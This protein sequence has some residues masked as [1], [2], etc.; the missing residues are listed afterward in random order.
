M[1]GLRSENAA[2]EGAGNV[3][4]IERVFTGEDGKERRVRMLVRSGPD[5]AAMDGNMAELEGLDPADR[6]DM[7][8]GL[9]EGLAEADRGLA[10]LPRIMAEAQ[11]AADG[12]RAAS[13]TRVIVRHECKPGSEEVSESTTSNGTQVVKFFLHM[14]KG[15]QRRRLIERLDDPQKHWKFSLADLKERGYWKQYQEAYEEMLSA[16]STRWAPWH[17]LP[18]DNKWVCRAMAAAILTREITALKLGYPEVSPEHR[19]ALVDA[20]RRLMAERKR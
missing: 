7:L 15:E 11:A 1:V 12:A 5:G 4:V 10:D 2:P 19:A 14:S 3:E 18:A 17:V 9:R 6:E 20:R 13:Q 8:A 16:T